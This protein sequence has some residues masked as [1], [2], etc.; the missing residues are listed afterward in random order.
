MPSAT[1]SATFP[2]EVELAD[3]KKYNM[4]AIGDEQAIGIC[5]K[6]Y[7][8]VSWKLFRLTE[9]RR[10]PVCTESPKCPKPDTGNS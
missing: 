2:Y 8:K 1:E 5:Q 9:G 4:E 6:Q 3:G 10:E 7:P